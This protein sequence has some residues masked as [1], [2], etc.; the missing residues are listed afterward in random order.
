MYKDLQEIRD[1]FRNK[2]IDPSEFIKEVTKLYDK[3]G[4][5]HSK[6]RAKKMMEYYKEMRT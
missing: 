6:E 4:F 1:M 5:T 2:M 3:F